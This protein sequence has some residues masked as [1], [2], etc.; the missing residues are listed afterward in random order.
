MT[1]EIDIATHITKKNK[2]TIEIA[3]ND[4]TDNAIIIAIVIEIEIEIEIAITID[5]DI[6]IATENYQ[7]QQLLQLVN[8]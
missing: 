3:T 1:S 7:R 8:H 2:I 6:A 4:T 5:I